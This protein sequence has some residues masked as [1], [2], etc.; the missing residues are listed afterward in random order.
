MSKKPSDKKHG[1]KKL[2]DN[3]PGV[4][5]FGNGTGTG[6]G[7]TSNSDKVFKSGAPS[8]QAGPGTVVNRVL[9]KR[10]TDTEPDIK[11]GATFTDE[12]DIKLFSSDSNSMTSSGTSNSM[13]SGYTT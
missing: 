5:N 9:T 4:L 8:P 10:E 11:A 3:I 1:K 13:T 2:V 12:E 7:L 6:T